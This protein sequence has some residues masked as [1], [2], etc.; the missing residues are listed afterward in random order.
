MQRFFHQPIRKFKQLRFTVLRQYGLWIPSSILL[1]DKAQVADK[2][3]PR[4]LLRW[5]SHQRLIHAHPCL[6]SL[7]SYSERLTLRS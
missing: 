2:G 6:A 7:P 4:H 5:P 1:P 3:A